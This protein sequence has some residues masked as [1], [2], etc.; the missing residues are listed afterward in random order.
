MRGKEDAA[1]Y[2]YFPDPDLL[3]LIITDEMLEKYSQIPELPDEKKNRFINELG[4]KDYDASILT[5]S[6]DMAQFFEDMISEGI[7]SKNAISWLSVELQGRLKDGITISSSPV[8]A[9]KLA[10]LVKAIENQDISAKAAKEVLDYLMQND[11]SVQEAIE[12]LGLKQV[13]NDD[14]IL[15]IIDDIIS[16]NIDKVEQYKNGK[17]KLFGFFVGQTMKASKGTANPV[18]VNTL[19][20]KRLS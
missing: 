5:S 3:P 7:S 18:K 4:I 15:K 9:K 11:K 17:D 10:S 1:D 14:D 12:I 6:K 19:L 2:R 13:S 20:K 8:K 16:S